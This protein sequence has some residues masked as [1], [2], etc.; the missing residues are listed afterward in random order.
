MNELRNTYNAAAHAF[1]IATDQYDRACQAFPE[2]HSAVVAAENA[3]SVAD[4]ALEYASLQNEDT[5]E[6]ENKLLYAKSVLQD[7]LFHMN[8]VVQDAYQHK[9]YTHLQYV[10]ARQNYYR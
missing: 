7:A 9:V 5:N 10:T 6:H 4:V 3:V 2:L 1:E 8:A